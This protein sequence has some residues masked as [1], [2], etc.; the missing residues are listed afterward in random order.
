MLIAALF[1]MSS[2]WKQPICLSSEEQMKKM[3]YSCPMEYYSAIK[4][5]TSWILFANR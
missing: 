3:W 1:V 5:K 2:N 4:T